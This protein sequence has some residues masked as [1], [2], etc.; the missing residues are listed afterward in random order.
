M[1]DIQFG[2]TR[3]DLCG[4]CRTK[5][6]D[7]DLVGLIKSVPYHALCKS[8]YLE[9]LT[10]AAQ[11]PLKNLKDDGIES[12][13]SVGSYERVDF[14]SRAYRAQNEQT[15]DILTFDESLERLRAAGFERHARPQEAFGLIIDGLEGKLN[16]ELS[17]VSADMSTGHGEWLSLAFERKGELLVCYLDPVG[18]VWTG[19]KYDKQNFGYS[20]ECSFDINGITSGQWVGLDKFRPYF[21]QFLCGRRFDQLPTEMREGNKKVHVYLPSDGVAW[22][23]ARG[24]YRFSV[25]GFGSRYGVYGD[26]A[27]RGVRDAPRFEVMSDA[28]AATIWGGPGKKKSWLGRMF[29]W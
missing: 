11:K 10:G 13:V 25:S 20:G 8:E 24:D 9:G 19:I 14:E 16:G 21:V 6:T 18:L 17:K 28:Q 2:G 12:V 29:G 23:V 1:S 27:S 3:F 15:K 26:G 22:P 4:F 7:D 5:I